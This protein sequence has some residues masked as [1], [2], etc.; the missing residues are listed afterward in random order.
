MGL[1]FPSML[2]GCHYDLGTIYSCSTPDWSLG[3][4]SVVWKSMRCHNH[5]GTLLTPYFTHPP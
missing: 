1:T 3:G 5:T 2:L 4:A